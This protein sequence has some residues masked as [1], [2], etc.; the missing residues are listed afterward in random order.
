VVRSGN[1]GA[2]VDILPTRQARPNLLLA[3]LDNGRKFSV[4]HL[5]KCVRAR[6]IRV[7]GEHGSRYLHKLSWFRGRDDVQ[8]SLPML[9]PSRAKVADQILLKSSA[10]AFVANSDVAGR[11]SLF[12]ARSG[13]CRWSSSRLHRIH[14]CGDRNG[15]RPQDRG[16][17]SSS[18]A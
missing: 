2:L 11:K 8:C 5:L 12:A 15:S 14:L 13:L 6:G 1:V 4:T 10:A 17:Q 16:T 18:R 9:S 7:L 3:L